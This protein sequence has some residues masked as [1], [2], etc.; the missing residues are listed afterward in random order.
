LQH[1]GLGRS[2]GAARRRPVRGASRCWRPST[3]TNA[4]S[5]ASA[6]GR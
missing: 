6:S 3:A 5:A 4:C 1:I 2:P